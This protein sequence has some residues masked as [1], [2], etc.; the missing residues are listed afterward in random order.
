MALP[1]GTEMA[2]FAI[3]MM[4]IVYLNPLEEKIKKSKQVKK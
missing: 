3:F 2:L 1:T 4:V